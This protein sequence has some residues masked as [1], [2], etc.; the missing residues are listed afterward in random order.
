MVQT[1]AE[2]H[3]GFRGSRE[4]A[5]SQHPCI[6]MRIVHLNTYDVAGGAA[7]ATFRL[8]SGLNAMGQDSHL[9]VCQKQSSD[10]YTHVVR[11]I[12]KDL[13]LQSVLQHN[14]LELNSFHLSA[15][16]HQYIDHNRTDVSN[17]LFSFPYPGLDLT[18][19]PIIQSADIIHLHWMAN[20]QSPITLNAL[21]QLGKPV[22]WTL[23]DMWPFTG[24]CHSSGHCTE[25]Q[26]GCHHCPQLEQDPLGLPAAVLQDKLQLLR[27]PNLTLVA[28]SKPIA[29]V[30]RQSQLFQSARVEVI[31]HAIDT[32][33]FEPIDKTTAKQQ[34]GL[35][36][37]ARVI[38]FGSENG[39]QRSK[40]MAELIEVFRLC[41]Q[42]IQFRTVLEQQH[43]YL[44]CCGDSHPEI[45]HLHLPLVKM[46]VIHDDARLRQFYSAADVFVQPSLEESFGN[47]AIESLCCGTPVIGFDVGVAPEA[48]APDEMGKVVPL[49]DIQAMANAVLDFALHPEKWQ[50]M[51]EHCHRRATEQFSQQNQSQKVLALYRDLLGEESVTSP[52]HQDRH[53]PQQD[54]DH[55][56]SLPWD[57]RLGP[58][59][60]SITKAIALG[61]LSKELQQVQT[62]L[63]HREERLR[64][65]RDRIQT[66]RQ[67]LDVQGSEVQALKKALSLK[68][69]EV[70]AM[71]TSKFWKLRMI[72]MK[73]RTALK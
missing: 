46:G 49:G 58:A 60:Q 31:H 3:S 45:D 8:H 70:D 62:A 65:M 29:T 37:N 14:E 18:T 17:I 24:G 41:Q 6:F 30:A 63:H 21:L 10:P 48:I 72:W 23:H 54:T 39:Q 57:C 16:Q 43:L 9:V 52:P 51:G 61:C 26:T 55:E 68:N 4:N 44:V 59:T 32:H 35:P 22:V 36:P 11:A 2:I 53:I 64:V 67:Q 1:L 40:G 20:Y 15:L 19:L 34:I 71:K 7:R 5:N 25:Y 28:P 69:G 27:A 13:A 66:L 12:A 50:A 73:V 42:D 47:M 38:A 33:T 56:I